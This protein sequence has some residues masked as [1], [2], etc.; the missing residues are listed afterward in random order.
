MPESKPTIELV[1]EMGRDLDAIEVS[2]VATAMEDVVQRALNQLAHEIRA[3][4]RGVQETRSKLL[5]HLE[6]ASGMDAPATAVR[7]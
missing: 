2:S 4:L 1:N 5:T 3:H 7:S 6:R